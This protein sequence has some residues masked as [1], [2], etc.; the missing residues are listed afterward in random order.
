MRALAV[1]RR[2]KPKSI[3]PTQAEPELLKGTWVKQDTIAYIRQ[4]LAACG[5]V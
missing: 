2:R 1:I 3:M 4:A 5:P